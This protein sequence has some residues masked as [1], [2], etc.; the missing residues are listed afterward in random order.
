HCVVLDDE[1]L[2]ILAASGAYVVHNPRSNMKLSS[3]VAPVPAMLGRGLGLGLGTDGAA[4]NNGLNM[5][6]EMNACALLHKVH[7]MDPTL[8]PAQTVLD[9]A[10]LGGAGALNWPGLGR[11]EAGAFADLVALDLASPN[12]LPMYNPVSHLVYSATGHEVR[13][14]MVEGKVLYQDGDYLA[15]DLAALVKEAD[16]LKQWVLAK[17]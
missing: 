16:K 14:T 3:G 15:F 5:F 4:S 1:E 6:M 10:T 9:M 12:L 11:L 13:L 17:R 8:C 7:G 2:D